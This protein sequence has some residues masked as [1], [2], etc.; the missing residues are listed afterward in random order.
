MKEKIEVKRMILHSMHTNFMTYVFHMHIDEKRGGLFFS[1]AS[2]GNAL[3]S[4]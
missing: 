2:V 4:W 1:Y 3:F